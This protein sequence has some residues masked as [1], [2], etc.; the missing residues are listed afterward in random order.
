MFFPIRLYRQRSSAGFRR[1]PFGTLSFILI[2]LAVSFGARDASALGPQCT[3]PYVHVQDGATP[4]DP[5][6][7]GELTIQS[8]SVGEP[9]T[10]CF[11]KRI[12]FVLKVNTMDPGNTGTAHPQP[13]AAWQV[14]F[15]IPGSKNSSGANRIVYVQYVTPA[16]NPTGAFSYGYLDPSNGTEVFY[17]SPTPV[18]GTLNP[19]GT[20][21]FNLDIG[22][23]LS[24]AAATGGGDPAWSIDP[25]IWQGF[26]LTQVQGVTRIILGG[27]V[28]FQPVD[29]A[30]TAGDGVYPLL[31]N[32]SCSAPPI[33]ALAAMPTSGNAPLTVNFDASASTPGQCGTINSYIFNFGDGVQITQAGATISHTYTTGGVTYGARARV[34]SDVGLTSSNIAQQNIQVNSA[35]PPV[36]T[37]VASRMTHG[38][39]GDF[40]IVLPQPPN[41]RAIECRSS[42]ALGAGNYKLIFTFLNN[43]VSVASASVT[44]GVGSV[45]NN[46][47]GPNT[48]QYT[49]NLTGV[50][51]AQSTTVTL[52]TAVDTAGSSGDVPATIGVL[53]GDV[54]GNAVVSNTDV[55]LVKGQVTL[56]VGSDNFRNDVNANG[57]ISNTD[58]TQTKA[59]VGN[60]LP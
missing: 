46:G 9:F 43:L 20:I 24:F 6:P 53:V 34:T 57:V 29:D 8:V 12:T 39:A 50:A 13:E 48:N 38:A 25:S 19:N 14:R 52:H 47:L 10:S 30:L 22:S 26:T 15:L 44:G 2:A 27:L 33:A 32:L 36:L 1:Y 16:S 59:Q 21:T 49:V 51:S 56:P 23:T 45:L 42:T 5:D 41:A 55:S 11:T 60:T 54:N 28:L 58:V 35:G 40:D 18:T 17:T 37:S 7:T 31:G 3:A 4:A